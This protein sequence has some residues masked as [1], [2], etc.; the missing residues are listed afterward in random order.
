MP[1]R[2]VAGDASTGPRAAVRSGLLEADMKRA[3]ILMLAVLANVLCVQA[4]TAAPGIQIVQA[5]VSITK[6]DGVRLR[7]R[8]PAPPTPSSSAT[9]GPA[10]SPGPRVRP[11]A[12]RR[13]RRHLGDHG[14]TGGGIVTGPASG[15]GA[16]GDHRRPA[17]RR[18]ASPS[19]SRPPSTRRRPARLTN[20]A[21]VSPPPA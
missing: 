8:A 3:C 16:L 10:P 5:D 17:G 9:P 12:G 21:T 4:A 13:H 6:T 20:T 14:S 19:R 2:C 18:H 15:S 1:P 7:C 11:A